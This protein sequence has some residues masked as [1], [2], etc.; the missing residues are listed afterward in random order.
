MT[1]TLT[2][3]RGEGTLFLY[4]YIFMKASKISGI[5][6]RAEL[7]ASQLTQ[8]STIANKIKANCLSCERYGEKRV[9]LDFITP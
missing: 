1:T 7:V 5:G 6:G 9:Y 3:S 8:I 4:F 2:R